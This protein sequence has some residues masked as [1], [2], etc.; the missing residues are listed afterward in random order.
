MWEQHSHELLNGSNMTTNFK[1]LLM[2]LTCILT[3]WNFWHLIFLKFLKCLKFDILWILSKYSFLLYILISYFILKVLVIISNV[4]QVRL[5]SSP[6]RAIVKFGQE[7]KNFIV[8]NFGQEYHSDQSPIAYQ[9]DFR[10]Y[11]YIFNVNKNFNLL[12]FIKGSM[13]YNYTCPF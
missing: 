2:Y 3:F 9:S 6:I 10:V 13:T 7:S 4:Y 11:I 12:K 1:R 5:G 8:P